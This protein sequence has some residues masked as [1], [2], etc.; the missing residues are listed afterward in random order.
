MKKTLLILGVLLTLASNA[1]SSGAF[2]PTPTES[3][4]IISSLQKDE[5]ESEIFDSVLDPNTID[6]SPEWYWAS[7]KPVLVQDDECLIQIH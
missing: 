4:N 5:N 1:S 7:G 2:Q 3:D 6:D